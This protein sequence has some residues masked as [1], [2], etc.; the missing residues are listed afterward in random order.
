M[1]TE[2]IEPIFKWICLL[3]TAVTLF[4]AAYDWRDARY[5]NLVQRTDNLAVTLGQLNNLIAGNPNL[6]TSVNEVLRDNG[7]PQYVKPIPALPDTSESK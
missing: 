2:K 7:Y 5:E 6:S 1:K 4:F 3:L